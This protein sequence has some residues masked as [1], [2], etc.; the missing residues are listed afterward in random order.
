VQ[1]RQGAEKK[2]CTYT[3][4][5]GRVIY[6]V[7]TLICVS[8]SVFVSVSVK[9]VVAKRTCVSVVVSS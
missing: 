2:R 9:V 8:V 1:P 3:V 5:G 4:I 7:V 6:D